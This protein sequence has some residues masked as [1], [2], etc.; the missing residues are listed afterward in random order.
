MLIPLS[1]CFPF[2]AAYTSLP[3]S[4]PGPGG[5]KKRH[6]VYDRQ[7]QSGG[8]PHCHSTQS[9]SA[10]SSTL[11]SLLHSIP[12]L[13]DSSDSLARRP[14]FSTLFP[15]HKADGLATPRPRPGTRG[16]V[17]RTP[18]QTVVPFLPLPRAPD[19]RCLRLR[20]V[21]SILFLLRSS[22]CGSSRIRGVEL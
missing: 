12:F 6:Y 20:C 18:R 17:D 21:F 14:W 9:A 19:R 1:L 2:S 3:S 7:E 22:L 5:P 10:Q 11:V 8:T 15:T 4:P 16:G 13:W